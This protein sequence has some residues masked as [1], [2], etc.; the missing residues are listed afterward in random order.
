MAN[1]LHLAKLAQGVEAWNTW[2]KSN[3]E[4]KSRVQPDLNGACIYGAIFSELRQNSLSN[5]LF[6]SSRARWRRMNMPDL[7]QVDLSGINFQG[8]SLQETEFYEPNF[9]GTNF[10]GAFLDGANLY[11]A[12]LAGADLTNASLIKTNLQGAIFKDTILINS[13]LWDTKGLETCNHVGESTID[14]NTLTHSNGLPTAFLRGFGLK[15]WQIEASKFY[16]DRPLST[17]EASDIT[18]KIMDLRSP[19]SVQ[20]YSCFISYSHTDKEFAKKLHDILQERGIRCWLDEHQL[21]PGDDLYE[22]IDRGV[23]LWDKTLLC[24]SSSSLMSWWVDSEIDTTF[25]KERKIMK[26]RGIKVLA[27]IPLNLD[28]FMFTEH[29]NNGKKRQVLSRI[30]ADFTGWENNN[31]KFDEQIE[32]ILLSLRVGE[33]NREIPPLP[34]L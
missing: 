21:L 19:N 20:Y 6:Y 25:E 29:W 14:L 11:G 28:G 1:P 15:D 17:R 2:M 34:L 3:N 8:V 27:L 33:Q 23:T 32:K 10:K 22:Q 26:E 9:T 31:I 13:Y 4:K 18:H 16:F 24:C 30:A 5:P 12:R 7:F